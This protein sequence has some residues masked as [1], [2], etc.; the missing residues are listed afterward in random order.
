[1]H[2]VAGFGRGS[3]DHE[4][5]EQLPIDWEREGSR[6][7][8][9]GTFGSQGTCRSRR[10][11][12]RWEGPPARRPWPGQSRR[13][14]HKHIFVRTTDGTARHGKHIY[15]RRAALPHTSVCAALSQGLG[16]SRT[17]FIPKTGEVNA[18]GLLIRSPESLR[19]LTL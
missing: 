12:Q 7:G 4:D 9:S 16:A 8:S 14:T 6:T 17:V 19:P 2:Q 11:S 15:A 3:A 10:R 1:M 5:L 18:V 13:R